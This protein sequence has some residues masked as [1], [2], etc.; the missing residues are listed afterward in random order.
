[1]EGGEDGG[2]VGEGVLGAGKGGRSCEVAVEEEDL[3]C[4]RGS[5]ART[6]ADVG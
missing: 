3:P 6:F 2:V 1:M 5:G 4:A